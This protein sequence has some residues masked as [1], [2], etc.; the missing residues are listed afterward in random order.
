MKLSNVLICLSL[1]FSSLLWL[2][3]SFFTF[4]TLCNF[5]DALPC[6]PVSV[7]PLSL[8]L[9][10]SASGVYGH[11]YYEAILNNRSL[12]PCDRRTELWGNMHIHKYI[13]T[14]TQREWGTLPEG[15]NLL[16]PSPS[17]AVLFVV[18]KG[19]HLKVTDNTA[20]NRGTEICI[21]RKFQFFWLFLTLLFH[22]DVLRNTAPKAASIA[23]SIQW[24]IIAAVEYSKHK[25]YNPENNNPLF[26]GFSI[27]HG[28]FF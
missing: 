15:S 28:F 27:Y 26:M 9:T 14:N 12:A 20:P 5:L 17:S 25:Q 11:R 18:F 24:K 21:S 16:V 7:S 10:H 3:V 22:R 8:T 2:F 19:L 4:S 6:L 13:Y 1:L 23:D